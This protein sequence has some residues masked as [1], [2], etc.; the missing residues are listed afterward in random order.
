[1]ELSDYLL[2]A[3]L[4]EASTAFHMNKKQIMEQ[5]ED[6]PVLSDRLKH[7]V[8]DLTF[9]SL[10]LC[11]YIWVTATRPILWQINTQGSLKKVD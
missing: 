7:T 8:K 9:R 2:A 6:S 4:Q 11:L 5:Q 1:M 10:S 3:G